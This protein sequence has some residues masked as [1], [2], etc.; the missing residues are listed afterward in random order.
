[1]IINTKNDESRT[2]FLIYKTTNMLNSKIYIGKHRTNNANDGYIGSGSALK[3]SI[4]TYGKH[5]FKREILHIFDNFDEMNNK[6]SELVNEDFILREDTYNLIT[7]GNGA[8]S[9][10]RSKSN[11]RRLTV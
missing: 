1:M 7:G 5:N 2:L 10:S 8:Y 9:K 4:K 3:R 11:K 6:E